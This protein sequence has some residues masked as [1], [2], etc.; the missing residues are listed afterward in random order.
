MQFLTIASAALFVASGVA[1]EGMANV[2]NEC[3]APVYLWSISADRE[4]PM[5][6]IAPGDAYN[7]TYQ[8]PS[9]G[10]VSL[11]LNL[12]PTHSNPTPISQ[13]EYTLAGGMIWGDMSNVNCGT[14]ECPFK[15]FGWYLD[16]GSQDCPTRNCEANAERCTGAYIAYNDDVN[17]ISCSE[18][19]D[20][21]L[22]LCTSEAPA[23]S[24]RSVPVDAAPRRHAHH[25]IRHPHVRSG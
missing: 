12:E 23:S 16:M 25:I 21:S 2:Y 4:G 24:K 15:A 13:F 17:T 22:Y 1:A 3:K 20:I 11:K 9:V 18:S 8:V 19:S 10:G 14:S 7:E 5:V 6:T